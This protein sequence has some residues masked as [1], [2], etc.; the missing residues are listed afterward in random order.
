M[1]C[2]RTEPEAHS[3]PI[4]SL[5]SDHCS[6]R[7]ALNAISIPICSLFTVH[8]SQRAALPLRHSCPSH[9]ISP[10]RHSCEGR[11]LKTACG[12][13]GWEGRNPFIIPRSALHVASPSVHCSLITA[14]REQHPMWVAYPSVH[15]KDAVLATPLNPQANHSHCSG[16]PL[17]AT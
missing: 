2:G 13:V 9:T 16:D 6:Q 11:N 15:C 1:T 3:V 4:C 8:C 12:L 17:V 10:D 7:A 5:I 14:Y